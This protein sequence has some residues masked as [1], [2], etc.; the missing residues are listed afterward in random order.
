MTKK[1]PCK[2]IQKEKKESNGSNKF[3]LVKIWDY[4]LKPDFN[5]Q[6][7][8]GFFQHLLDSLDS[9]P[10]I[11]VGYKDPV[12]KNTTRNIHYSVF[13]PDSIVLRN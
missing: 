2:S 8:S 1:D 3:R 7:I 11:I 12:I 13:Y 4:S 9:T 10:T 5:C 6:P